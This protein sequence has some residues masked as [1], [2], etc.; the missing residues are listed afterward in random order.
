VLEPEPTIQRGVRAET[1]VRALPPEPQYLPGTEPVPG[2]VEMSEPEPDGEL[3][4]VGDATASFTLAAAPR[5]PAE[6]LASARLRSARSVAPRPSAEVE[7]AT[8]IREPAAVPR[9]FVARDDD[10]SSTAATASTPASDAAPPGLPLPAASVASPSL[11]LAA[12]SPDAAAST[13]PA[14]PGEVSPISAAALPETPALDLEALAGDLYEHVRALLTQ[15]L[16]LDRER[17]IFTPELR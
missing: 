17:T 16:V 2:A 14:A 9:P 1:D 7:W 5:P 8:A 10:G 15:E 4:A 12:S 6:P 11:P 3:A 13:E